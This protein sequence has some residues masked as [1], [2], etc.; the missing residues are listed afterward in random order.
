MASPLLAAFWL[1]DA[2]DSLITAVEVAAL[3]LPGYVFYLVFRSYLDAVDVRPLSSV[4]TLS[5]LGV[6]VV[7]LPVA[8]G[9]GLM[10]APVGATAALSLALT[11]VGGVTFQLT[12]R[13]I[14]GLGD[15]GRLSAVWIW[16][17]FALVLGVVSRDGAPALVAGATSVAACTLALTLLAAHPRWLRVLRERLRASGHDAG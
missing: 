16:L 11:V 5:G 15:R 7:A 6:L 4:A 17:P 1:P 9:L 2:P 3:G 8:L 13:R 10:P 14:H 12:R